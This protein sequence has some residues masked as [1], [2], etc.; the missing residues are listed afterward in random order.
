MVS[1]GAAL[2]QRPHVVIATPG[3]LADL[4]RSGTSATI[5]ARVRFLVRVHTPRH[6]GERRRKGTVGTAALT[7]VCVHSLKVLDEADRLLEPSFAPD[8]STVLAALPAAALPAATAVPASEVARATGGAR[9]Q[10][11]LFS[12]TLTSS[13]DQL[14]ALSLHD[15][16]VYHATPKSARPSAL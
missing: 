10:T 4:L 9:R 7:T 12:A 6:S 15:P 11:L 8:L 16:F 14:A 1:Q 5:F 13:L 3:R 2:A